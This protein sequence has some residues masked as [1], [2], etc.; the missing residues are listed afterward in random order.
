MSQNLKRD[1]NEYYQQLCTYKLDNLE[2]MNKF[3]EKLIYQ[4]CIKK[5]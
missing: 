1:I 4:N 3:L 2:E 5:K